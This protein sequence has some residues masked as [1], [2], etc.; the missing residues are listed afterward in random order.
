[1]YKEYGTY[2]LQHADIFS[3]G[4]QTSEGSQHE[5]YTSEDEQPNNRI[6]EKGDL[7]G[8]KW[9]EFIKNTLMKKNKAFQ[10]IMSIQNVI[11][12]S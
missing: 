3:E 11:I 10:Y 7:I 4:P 9:L 1:M 8:T 2:T 12:L 6:S 5:N